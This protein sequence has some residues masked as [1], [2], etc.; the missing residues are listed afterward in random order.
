MTFKEALIL[1]NKSENLIGE[2]TKKGRIDEILIVPTNEVLYQK[3]MQE[4]IG[5]QNAQV[6]ILPYINEEVKVIAVINKSM[7]TT[8]G[9]FTFEDVSNIEF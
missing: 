7:I 5:T 9:M 8:L 6:A 1:A 3:Y 4:Y 2:I